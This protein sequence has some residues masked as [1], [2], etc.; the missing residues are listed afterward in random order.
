MAPL[1]KEVS[2]VEGA[3]SE[4]ELGESVTESTPKP[5]GGQRS[6]TGRL[7][8]DAYAGAERVECRHEELAGGQRGPVCGQGTLYELP[9]GSEM[10]LNGH[11]M[12]S[13]LR[14]EL[15]QLRC[16]ACGHIFTAKLPEAA[17]EEK[18]RARARAV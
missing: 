9:P 7:G 15:Q 12:L 18:Y 6:G 1:D 14:Y 16:S 3:E 5:A 10:R 17:G 8:A 13:A 4:A 11:A 2:G